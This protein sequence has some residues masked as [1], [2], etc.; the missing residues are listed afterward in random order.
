MGD[1]GFL[2]TRREENREKRRMYGSK[3]GRVPTCP[4]EALCE[5]GSPRAPHG[6]KKSGIF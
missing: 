3:F 4:A 1:A 6:M 2:F 5:G